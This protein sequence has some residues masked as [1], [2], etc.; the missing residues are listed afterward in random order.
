MGHKAKTDHSKPRATPIDGP[1]T[2]MTRAYRRSFRCLNRKDQIFILPDGRRVSI[3]QLA[4]RLGLTYGDLFRELLKAEW[5]IEE[6]LL[7]YPK[8][9]LLAGGD[10]ISQAIPERP[11]GSAEATGDVVLGLLAGGSREDERGRAGLDET[12]QVKEGCRV[13]DPRGLLHVV[14][15]DDDGIARL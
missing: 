5:R 12:A 7:K 8:R 2:A 10:G 3:R 15:D 14:R 4:N 9:C 13:G 6:I 1:A 11:P